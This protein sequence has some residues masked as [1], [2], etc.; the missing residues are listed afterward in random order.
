M[1]FRFRKAA[2]HK[3]R[4]KKLWQVS[5]DPACNKEFSA[6]IIKHIS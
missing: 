3:K 1:I 6:N 2:E 5:K 4:L